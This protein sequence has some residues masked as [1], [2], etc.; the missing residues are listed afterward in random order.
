LCRVDDEFI[1]SQ[2][3]AWDAGKQVIAASVLAAAWLRAGRRLASEQWRGA[4][5][6]VT[7]AMQ[8]AGK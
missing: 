5:P 2:R 6:V 1:G 3:P 4:L 7:A 8:A